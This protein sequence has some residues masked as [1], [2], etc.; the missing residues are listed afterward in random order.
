MIGEGLLA[1]DEAVKFL[2][3]RVVLGVGKPLDPMFAE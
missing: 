1:G 3:R 2:A